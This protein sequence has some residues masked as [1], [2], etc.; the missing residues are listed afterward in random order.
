MSKSSGDELLHYLII[1]QDLGYHQGAPDLVQLLSSVSA[2]LVRLTQKTLSNFP[3]ALGRPLLR[4]PVFDF[5]FSI[6]RVL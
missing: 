4:F 1:S 3:Q 6:F 5:R 2:M